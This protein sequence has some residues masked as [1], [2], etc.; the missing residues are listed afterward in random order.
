MA[1]QGALVLQRHVVVAAS[2]VVAVAG[3]VL[4]AAAPV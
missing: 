4:T 2:S 3:L 1:D